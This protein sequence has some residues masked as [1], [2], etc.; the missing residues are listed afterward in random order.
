MLMLDAKKD[1]QNKESVAA[2]EW[3]VKINEDET[4]VIPF[5]CISEK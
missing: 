1:E 5:C 4:P 3:N 2:Q